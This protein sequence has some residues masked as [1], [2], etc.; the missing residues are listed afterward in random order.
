MKTTLVFDTSA[1]VS[2]GHTG[3]INII[4]K[5]FNIIITRSIIDELNEIS[6]GTDDDAKSA[7]KWLKFTQNLK[8]KKSKSNKIGVGDLFEICLKEN[9]SLIT[10]DIK[11][12]KKFKDKIKCYYGVHIIYILF[13]KG[14]ISKERAIMSV[15]KMRTKRSWK[16]NII[17]V[18][19]R[20]LFDE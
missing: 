7:R 14:K 4:L 13:K 17:Y 1:L 5:N 6:K 9:R 10:D 8:I 18:T 20:I 12:I 16:S 2:L 11:A 19:S 15:E 3:I